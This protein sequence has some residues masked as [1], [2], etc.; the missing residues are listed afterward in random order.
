MLKKCC[1]L[2][3]LENF[4]E[5]LGEL[6]I[7]KIFGSFPVH[8]DKNF[9]LNWRKRRYSFVTYKFDRLTLSDN[10]YEENNNF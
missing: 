10:L 6:E 3:F 2:Q 1:T 4:E 8:L 7:L 9:D 5:I